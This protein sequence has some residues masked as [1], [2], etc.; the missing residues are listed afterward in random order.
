M[1]IYQHRGEFL[2]AILH[3]LMLQIDQE[4]NTMKCNLF[5]IFSKCLIIGKFLIS[6]FSMSIVERMLA[7]VE[8]AKQMMWVFVN[9]P[10]NGS[11]S[12]AG[13]RHEQQVNWP[14]EAWKQLLE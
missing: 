7:L 3:I 2:I 8:N 14:S 9:F 4:E 11:G 6:Y 5:V 1:N 10:I 12:F 13:R